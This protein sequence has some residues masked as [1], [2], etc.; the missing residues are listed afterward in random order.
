MRTLRQA[1]LIERIDV[2]VILLARHGGGYSGYA[3]VCIAS[4][5]RA[6]LKQSGFLNQILMRHLTHQGS[7]CACSLFKV[8]SDRQ[9]LTVDGCAFL[10]L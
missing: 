5:E 6:G 3:R 9:R 4:N 7:F 1:G 8:S 2:E 10:S